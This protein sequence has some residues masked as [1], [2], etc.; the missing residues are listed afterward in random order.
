MSG[1][2]CSASVPGSPMGYVDAA[3]GEEVQ[4][5]RD[6]RFAIDIATVISLPE[7]K[8]NQWSSGLG[9]SL[10]KEFVK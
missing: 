5:A 8:G 9:R 10:G 7:S 6:A 1:V 4:H 3:G 2:L